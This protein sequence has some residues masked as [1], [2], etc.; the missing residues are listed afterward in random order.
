MPIFVSN[1]ANNIQVQTIDDDIT[2]EYEDTIRL[3]FTPV[4][5]N[6]REQLEAGG[7]FIRDTTSVVIIDN[8]GK[9]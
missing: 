1:S 9:L 4:V 5:S 7:E 8:D 2:L 3:T 6:L